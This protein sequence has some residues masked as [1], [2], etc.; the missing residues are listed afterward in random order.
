VTRRHRKSRS[1]RADTRNNHDLSFE[2]QIH[3]QHAA[4]SEPCEGLGSVL[5]PKIETHLLDSLERIKG[6]RRHLACLELPISSP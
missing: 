2:V 5:L 6:N 3:M 1:L 4:G